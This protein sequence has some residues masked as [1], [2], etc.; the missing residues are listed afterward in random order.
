MA[1]AFVPV[2]VLPLLFVLQELEQWALDVQEDFPRERS[3]RIETREGVRTTTFRQPWG[4][5]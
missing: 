1:L 3:R 4:V 5:G 2:L